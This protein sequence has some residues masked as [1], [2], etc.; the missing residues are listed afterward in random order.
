MYT[1]SRG[2]GKAPMA[3]RSLLLFLLV[4]GRQQV[5]SNREDQLPPPDLLLANVSGSLVVRWD[6]ASSSARKH[7]VHLTVERKSQ[8]A[9]HVTKQVCAARSGVRPYGKPESVPPTLSLWL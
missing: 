9:F 8:E 1:S 6:D 3:S 2:A 5:T 4:A 7:W